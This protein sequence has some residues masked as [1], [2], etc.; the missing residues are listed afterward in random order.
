MN[1]LSTT[2]QKQRKYERS[3]AKSFDDFGDKLKAGR[4][5]W[6]NGV[7]CNDPIECL[8][9]RTECYNKAAMLRRNY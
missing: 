2:E 7:I 8:A 4:G 3:L 1:K 9:K 6:R 5:F